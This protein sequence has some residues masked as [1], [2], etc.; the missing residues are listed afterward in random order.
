MNCTFSKNNI[1]L[2]KLANETIDFIKG[3]HDFRQFWYGQIISQMGDKIHSLAVLILV[4]HW[5]NSGLAV[6]IIMIATSLP[7]VLL[8]PVSGELADRYDR[9]KIMIITDLIRGI[10][11]L[12]LAVLSWFAILDMTILIIGTVLISIN[13]AFFNPATLSIIPNIVA[14][15]DLSRANAL[16]Q[17]SAN[18][19]GVVGLLMGTGLIALIGVSLAFAF[20]GLSFLFS[21]LFISRVMYKHIEIERIGTYLENLKSGFKA[22]LS[23]PLVKSMFLP[24]I[25]INFFFSSLVVILP[26]IAQGKFH[27]G[28]TG[29]GV[30]MASY[31]IGMFF[32]SFVMSVIKDKNNSGKYSIAGLIMIGVGFTIIGVS[33]SFYPTIIFLALAGFGLNV[34]NICLI[35]IYQKVLNNENR[36]KVFGIVTAASLSLQPISYGIMG[37]LT[38]IT[39]PFY[40]FIVSGIVIF[41]VSM[42]MLT[43]KEL[44]KV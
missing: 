17:S 38:E 35:T 18:L 26:V 31:T 1:R 44:A 42:Q 15:R 25:V 6:G 36:G 40:I 12:A 22:A 43:N 14:S 32:G 29:L 24:I 13:S 16:N 8:G 20:N 30:M 3:N 2:D 23:I 9:R 37:Y 4:Y 21:A 10:I 11:V 7:A 41:I 39:D 27:S 33:E 19:A 5:T 34:T 28:A